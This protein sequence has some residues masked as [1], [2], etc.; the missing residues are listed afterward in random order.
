VLFVPFSNGKPSG[1]PIDLLSGFLD[2]YGNAMGRPV[3][4]VNDHKGGVLVADD[5]G[6]T[7]WRVTAVKAASALTAQGQPVPQWQ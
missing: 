2:V 1:A 4:V 6:N 5:V 3:G 7:I